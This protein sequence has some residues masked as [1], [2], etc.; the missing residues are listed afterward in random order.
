V[1]SKISYA[2]IVI[3]Y[4]CTFFFDNKDGVAA[5]LKPCEK[6]SAICA[7]VGSNDKVIIITCRPL[8]REIAAWFTVDVQ[9]FAICR[10][11]NPES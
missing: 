7:A 11:L 9:G 4:F 8:N 6:I 1:G 2:D 5:A 3:Y 10:K